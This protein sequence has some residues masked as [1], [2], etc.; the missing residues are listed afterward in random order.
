MMKQHCYRQRQK[1]RVQRQKNR[2]HFAQEQN[3]KYLPYEG[4]LLKKWIDQVL[5]CGFSHKMLLTEKPTYLKAVGVL[6]TIGVVTP[7]V[8][9]TARCACNP[10]G[11]ATAATMES[12]NFSFRESRE[13]I[14]GFS[15]KGFSAFPMQ[16][17]E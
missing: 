3:P 5:R 12:I 14:K 9:R 16:R 15:A 7:S 1:S 2:V 11:R 17:Y 6:L 13:I 4:Y 8:H 10:M